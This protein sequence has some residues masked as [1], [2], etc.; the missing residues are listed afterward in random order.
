M[1]WTRRAQFQIY[2][3]TFLFATTFKSAL[4]HPALYPMGIGD[5]LP[6]DKAAES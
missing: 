1:C 4:G 3:E 5:I 2:A 6:R